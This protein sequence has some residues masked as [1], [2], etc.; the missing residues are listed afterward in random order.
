MALTPLSREP[1]LT[2]TGETDCECCEKS[3]RLGVENN[4]RLRG[5]ARRRR[6]KL[7]NELQPHKTLEPTFGMKR[8]RFCLHS[9]AR[10]HQEPMVLTILVSMAMST[11]VN[12]HHRPRSRIVVRERRGIVTLLHERGGIMQTRTVLGR[13]S[14]KK[15]RSGCGSSE[16]VPLPS[17]SSSAEDSD[18]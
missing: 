8:L 14:L 18:L 6:S 7:V 10:R 5:L 3:R 4:W 17:F 13:S 1:N 12:D 15:E 2:Q 9:Q 16:F 11:I